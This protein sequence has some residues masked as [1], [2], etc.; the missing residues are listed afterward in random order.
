MMA[1]VGILAA[2]LERRSTGRGRFVDV[3]MLDGVVSW[4]SVH[5]AAYLATGQIPQPG[6]ERLSGRYACYRIYR[7]ADGR[8][9]TVGALEPQFWA[10]LCNALGCPDLIPDQYGPDQEA[11]ARRLQE[12]FATRT[13][14]E[15]LQ[16]FD[17]IEACVGPVNDVAEALIDPQIAARGMV[18]EVGGARVGAGPALKLDGATPLRPAPGFGEHTAEVLATVGVEEADLAGLR[19]RG[20]I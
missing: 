19:A 18:A 7:T 14:N 17:G 6:G 8:Y 13:R 12:I 9:V 16:A 20:V 4:L 5:A 11:I 1:A 2:L 15:W 3:S 10:A